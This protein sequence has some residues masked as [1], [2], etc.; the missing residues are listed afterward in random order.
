MRA[1]LRSLAPTTFE[2]VAALVALYRP[3]P[4][5]AEL[6]QRVR[7]PQERPQ[8]GHVRPPRPRGDPRAHL[9]ADDLP[10]AADARRRSSSPATRS[11]RPT[12]S[13]RPPARRSASSSPRSARSSSTAASRSGHDREFGEQMFDT[14]E[15]FADYSFNKS[16]SVGYGFVAYQTAY[17][18]AN[19]P[20]EYLA[21]LLTSVKTQQGQGRGLPQR[22]PPARASRCSSPTSTRRR[23]TSRASSATTASTARSASGCR[24]CATS[25]RAWSRTIIAGARGERAVH[26]LLRLLRAR[27]PVGAQQA[28]DRVADQGRRR[29]TRSATPARACCSCSSRSSTRCSRRRREREAEGQ[30]SLF[31]ARSTARPTARRV[32]R[33]PRRSP[34]SSSTRAQRLAFEK[35][36]LG[37]YVSDHPLMG[38][39]RAL[40]RYVDVHARRARASC[41]DG[42]D[43]HRR[44]A[45]SP[46]CSRKYTKRGDLMATFV[47][48][49]LAAVDRGDGVPEDDGCSTASCSTTTRSSCVKGRLD[50]REDT[51][52]LMAMEITRPELVARQRPAGA[53]PGAGS[54]RSPT[55]RSRRLKEILAAAPRRQPGVRAPR[56]PGEDDRAP[57]RRR[58]PLR[59]RATASSP[60][61]ASSSA[62]TASRSCHGRMTCGGPFAQTRG[63]QRALTQLA[64]RQ[65]R[66]RRP[67]VRPGRLRALPRA[68]P[69]LAWAARAADRL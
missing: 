61:S 33:P 20:V 69:R 58:L 17:L 63:S 51:P 16:H 46:R 43:A 57:P 9:R 31:D 25:A 41:D 37:L 48:E 47:L 12:T 50:V 5:G 52:K 53:A 36:M 7:R 40:R 64:R 6:A 19:Y 1:L 2:D 32:R 59:R 42:D 65:H 38:A 62:P 24:R 67:F 35:E 26:R 66:L 23:A 68:G 44:R 45:S 56:G 60:S 27:R 22:V 4:D 15:P 34:T 55:P 8:A 54:A 13:A 14:I 3:G 11:K 39:E 28:H 10:G 21:A 29:S 18:K 49:D 30:L